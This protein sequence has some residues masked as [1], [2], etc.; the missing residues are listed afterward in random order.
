MSMYQGNL[1]LNAKTAKDFTMVT[2]ITGILTVTGKAKVELHHLSNVMAVVVD[3]NAHLS[4]PNSCEIRGGITVCENGAFDFFHSDELKHVIVKSNGRI[5]GECKKVRSIV[6][7]SSSQVS[8]YKCESVEGDIRIHDGIV[9]LDKCKSVG[10]CIDVSSHA[11]L[12]LAAC[13]QVDG[14]ITACDNSDVLLPAC[15]KVHGTI[16]PNVGCKIDLSGCEEKDA[17]SEAYFKTRVT[18][19]PAPLKVPQLPPDIDY[20]ALRA[21]MSPSMG[22]TF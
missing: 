20:D 22:I 5:S 21:F 18:Y 14:S 19:K 3:K 9:N 2:E 1:R 15:T 12:S 13:E 11:T 16:S 6:V 17:P 8:L 7:Y 10:G 4:L